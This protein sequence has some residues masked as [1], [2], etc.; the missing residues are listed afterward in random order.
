M[1]K[2]REMIK[3]LIN[4]TISILT[5][6]HNDVEE[7]KR[8]LEDA[9]A[10]AL[11]EIRALR[12]GIDNKDYFWIIDTQPK[13]IMHPYVLD[14]VGKDLNNYSDPTGKKLFVESVKLVKKQKSGYIEYMWQFKDDSTLILPKIS[15][16]SLFEPWQWIVGTGVYINDVK[17]EI[18][19]L[20]NELIVTSL[21]I[22][23]IIILIISFVTF[24][25]YKI[26]AKRLNAE[27]MLRIS[28][29]KYKSLVEAS[30]EALVMLKDFNV[31]QTNELFV[32]MTQDNNYYGKNIANY[33]DLPSDVKN[34][35][36][37]KST[38]FDPFE[39]I[40]K[41]QNNEYKNILINISAVSI[42]NDIYYIFTIRDIGSLAS[43]KQLLSQ[44]YEQIKTL[45]D[46]LN[47]GYVRI[48]IDKRAQLLDA[49]ITALNIL[50]I[51]TLEQ[52]DKFSFI[53]LYVDPN[54]E[55]SIRQ[56]LKQKEQINRKLIKIKTAHHKEKEVFITLKLVKDNANNFLHC[57]G[58]IEDKA[59]VYNYFSTWNIPS[60][61]NM[62][63]RLDQFLLPLQFVND[64]ATFTTVINLLNDYDY[65]YLIVKDKNDNKIGYITVDEILFPLTNYINFHEL[66]AF[67][68]MKSPLTIVQHSHTV[69]NVIN[70][71]RNNHQRLAIIE[72]ENTEVGVFLLSNFYEKNYHKSLSFLEELQYANSIQKLRKIKNEFDREIIKIILNSDDCLP[73]FSILS[74][75]HDLIVQKIISE[76]IKELG[77]P[78]C[79]FSFVVLGSEARR[80][81]TLAT[82][83]DNAIIYEDTSTSNETHSY[84]IKF[85][86]F[87][88]KVL[89]DLGYK[90][91]KGNNTAA[92][93]KW[94]QPISVW[95]SYFFEW[96]NKGNP[97]DLLDINIF[98]D[99][100]T[101]YGNESLRKQLI[102]HIQQ[103]T[104]SNKA[105]LSLLAQNIS[106]TKIFIS[107]N[108][109]IKE[110]ISL[111]VN[112]IRIYSL[113][114]NIGET[115]TINRLN[116]L[117]HKG[118]ITPDLHYNL[119]ESFK[120]LNLLRLKH[121]AKQLLQKTSPNNT[122]EY[123]SLNDFDITRLK[124]SIH[125]IHLL[126]NKISNDYKTYLQ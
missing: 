22:T 73:I 31:V 52:Q 115:S 67:Q 9:Q 4:A 53:S 1:D 5:K 10:M 80:E 40:L 125:I 11:Q 54:D 23:I 41:T 20:T 95:K 2:K 29:E 62:S 51:K 105:Y 3:E 102:N 121:Q 18:S 26:E 89:D 47:I 56:E 61:F 116:I 64:T 59:N 60:I 49:N 69:G 17:K 68:I 86:E 87:I 124:F 57:E 101:I 16:V 13:M 97:K 50:H 65:K 90:F 91:C 74:E 107:N 88:T 120:F 30:T 85:G 15:Y 93:P 123:T 14:L 19:Q 126:Q 111:I 45:L 96:I 55:L 39:T 21:V 106:Q 75:L 119:V 28:Y 72:K 99:L 109:K 32:Q 94:T 24:Q 48:S 6:Y 46:S 38:T 78:P 33:I 58:I 25:S 83:Q 118:I 79:R 37:Q 114:N 35:M 104:L 81:Q 44:I 8:S 36:I 98:F 92:N 82:D 7:G 71:L 66:R 100:R 43:T 76:A 103:T 122:I 84:F 12:Y 108:V 70:I 113:A 77:T 63:S 112:A 110:F 34:K 42:M 117:K 27:E